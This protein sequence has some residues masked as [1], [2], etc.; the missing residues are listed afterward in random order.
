MM[1]QIDI[2]HKYNAKLH[3][4]LGFSLQETSPALSFPPALLSAPNTNLKDATEDLGSR[5]NPV[6]SH[7]YKEAIHNLG[8][9][10]IKM[11]YTVVL[12]D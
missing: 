4:Y 8:R 6:G 7:K 11:L 3:S 2:R 5:F 12:C 1:D 10:Y 9:T